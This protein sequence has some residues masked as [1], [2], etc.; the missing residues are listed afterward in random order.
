MNNFHDTIW[1]P[2]SALAAGAILGFSIVGA[3][4]HADNRGEIIRAQDLMFLCND[5]PANSFF[6]ILKNKNGDMLG[7]TRKREVLKGLNN[8]VGAWAYANGDKDVEITMLDG[9]T[10][11]VK[12]LKSKKCDVYFTK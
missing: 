10:A 6:G 8:I 1:S 2:L 7:F 5:N 11:T 4:V 3:V 12:D 9:Q